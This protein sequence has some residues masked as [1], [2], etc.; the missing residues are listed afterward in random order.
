M[1]GKEIHHNRHIGTIAKSRRFQVRIHFEGLG[2]SDWLIEF[3]DW[4][5]QAWWKEE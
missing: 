5:L 3:I 2:K 1:I 4:R